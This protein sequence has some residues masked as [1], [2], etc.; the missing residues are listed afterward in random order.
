MTAPPL[1]VARVLLVAALGLNGQRSQRFAEEAVRSLGPAP[2][3]PKRARG[4]GDA[5]IIGSLFQFVPDL[6][7]EIPVL[8]ASFGDKKAAQQVA[9]QQ[10][11]DIARAQI[12]AAPYTAQI[13]Q[14]R[15]GTK[16][17]AVAAAGIVGVSL[18]AALAYGLSR[19]K[20]K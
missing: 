20:G 4:A 3:P 10:A 14:A 2:A 12:E 9:Q 11:A 5:G 13:E 18:A 19:R 15:E 6:A 8:A 1:G 7:R 16:M 17:V